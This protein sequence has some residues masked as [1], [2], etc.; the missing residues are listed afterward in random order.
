MLAF[1]TLKLWKLGIMINYGTRLDK[2]PNYFES[3]N[4]HSMYCFRNGWRIGLNINLPIQSQ[5]IQ[6]LG[7]QTILAYRLNLKST[8]ILSARYL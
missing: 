3:I 7:V 8:D 1:Y 4:I 5:E 6:F 2:V